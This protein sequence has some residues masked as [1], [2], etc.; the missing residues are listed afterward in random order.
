[1]T[2]DDVPESRLSPQVT[3]ARGEEGT[4]RFSLMRNRSGVL[5][6]CFAS[7][8]ITAC[9]GASEASLATTCSDWL[10][11]DLPVQEALGDDNG[12]SEPQEEIAKDLLGENGKETRGANLVWF[13][14]NAVAV[15]APD[16]TGTRPFGTLNDLMDWS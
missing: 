4:H 14:V 6:T 13:G 11:L 3:T 8:T 12:L 2:T 15:C 16:G 10:A 5:V 9:G 1:M 7:F